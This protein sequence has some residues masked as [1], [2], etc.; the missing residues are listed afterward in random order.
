MDQVCQCGTKSKL[1]H[2]YIRWIP[3]ERTL[4]ILGYIT[5]YVLDYMYVPV[6][7]NSADTLPVFSL[8]TIIIKAT[9]LRSI[10]QHIALLI[11]DCSYNSTL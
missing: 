9:N 5:Y 3:V 1:P 10:T 8:P 11:Q 6:S 2:L 7:A 4:Y